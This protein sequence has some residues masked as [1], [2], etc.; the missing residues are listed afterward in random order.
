MKLREECKIKVHGL[1]R[2]SRVTMAQS[3]GTEFLTAAAMKKKTKIESGV[4]RRV[5]S[6]PLL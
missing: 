6:R 5:D 1:V 2:V 4:V 3:G